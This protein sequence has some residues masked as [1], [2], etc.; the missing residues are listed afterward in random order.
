VLAVLAAV[1]AAAGCAGDRYAV[2]PDRA[3]AHCCWAAY[4]SQAG[5]TETTRSFTMAFQVEELS[6]QLIEALV[7]LM[8]RMRQRDM[9]DGSAEPQEHA[10]RIKFAGLAR[11]RR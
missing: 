11:R 10:G 5:E 7:L 1:E 9:R 8:P 3:S 2:S 6:I 4:G